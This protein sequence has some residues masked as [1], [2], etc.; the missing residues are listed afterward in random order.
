MP[1]KQPELFWNQHAKPKVD[2]AA[3]PLGYDALRES[4]SNGLVP[5]LTGATRHADEYLW[6]L[7][8]L[9]WA[10]DRVGVAVDEEVFKEFVLFERALKQYWL[11]FKHR[12]SAGKNVVKELVRGKKPILTKPL[13]VNER[14][15][16]LVGSYIVSLRGLGLVEPRT[17]RLESEAVNNLLAG[18]EFRAQG[19]RWASSWEELEAV[20]KSVLLRR[21]KRRF[22]SK[23]F[24]SGAMHYA[25]RAALRRPQAGGWSQLR[26]EDLT[27]EQARLARATKPVA[28][29]GEESLLAFAELLHGQK[30]L[31][32]A[33]QRRLGLLARAALSSNPWPEGWGS[34]NPLANAMRS[35]WCRLGQRNTAESLVD[36]HREVA[37]IRMT[38]PWIDE[39]GDKPPDFRKWSPSRGE[40]D[41]RFTNLRNL[42]NETEWRPSAR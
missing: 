25:A 40:P 10:S 26:P 24:E 1:A 19:V 39:P 23:L 31:S 41:F 7:I 12:S 32:D 11:K 28:R 35:S 16:G 21:S 6:T 9:R 37:R 27:P 5:L 20:F 38:E 3:D 14:A 33:R 13:L 22:G 15:T 2:R 30:R 17:I 4:M 36:L 34:H 18:A 42:V 8:G 29:L